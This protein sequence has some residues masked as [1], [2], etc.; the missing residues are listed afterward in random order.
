MPNANR[1]IKALIV[2]CVDYRL[3]TDDLPEF[4]RVMDLVEDA[5]LVT[6]PG[7]SLGSI[8][9]H[10]EELHTLGE[11]VTLSYTFL[12]K[13]H[14]FKKI[15]VLDHRDCGMYKHFYKEHYQAER[16]EETRQHARNMK[17]FKDKIE[18]SNLGL[19]IRFFIFDIV[20]FGSPIKVDEISFDDKNIFVDEQGKKR[21]IAW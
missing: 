5:D 21:T 18:K 4:A 20:P 12:Q 7:G 2:S 17:I 13:V 9:D 14:G 6:V 16:D 1:D 3:V 19:S 8:L 10:D 11:A 15:Y